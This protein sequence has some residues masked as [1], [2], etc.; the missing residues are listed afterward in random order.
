M[1]GPAKMTVIPDV[2]GEVRGYRTWDLLGGGMLDSHTRGYVWHNGVNFAVCP[3][4]PF[5]DHAVPDMLC[6]CGLYSASTPHHPQIP[7]GVFGVVEC[8]GGIVQHETGIQRSEK[9]RVAALWLDPVKLNRVQR[10][11][12]RRNY[13][14]TRMY[15]FRWRMIRAYPPAGT[16]QWWLYR[17]PQAAR[18]GVPMTMLMSSVIIMAGGT[19]LSAASAALGSAGFTLLLALG[20]RKCR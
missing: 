4:F 17:V 19:V 8:S 13:P 5:R 12:L 1:A 10:Q 3:Y 6:G 15:T 7:F 2:V 11:K 16:R 20:M 14:G 18:L 9:A